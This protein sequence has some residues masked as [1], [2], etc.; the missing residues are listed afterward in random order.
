VTRYAWWL[1]ALLCISIAASA[2]EPAIEARLEPQ[3]IGIEDTARLTVTIW[4][5]GNAIPKLGE[6]S[7]L[8][9]VYGPV[10]ESQFRWV[11][12]VASSSVNFI[13]TLRPLQVGAAQVGSI[14]AQVGGVPLATEPLTAVVVQGRLAPTPGPQ[15]PIP[16]WEP[17]QGAAGRSRKI[18]LR[19]LTEKRELYLGE[20]VTVRLVLDTNVA[21]VESFELVSPPTFPGWWTQQVKL[22]QPIPPQ[23]VEVQ[24]ARFYRHHLISHVLIPLRSGD[25]T[26]PTVTARIGVR[27]RRLFTTGQAVERSTEEL[28]LTVKERPIPPD[29]FNGAVGSLQYRAELQP[30]EIEL[31]ESAVLTIELSGIGNLPLVEAPPLWPGC[32]DCDTYPPEEDSNVQIDDSGIHGTRTW[33]TTIVP[34]SPG[35]LRLDPVILAYFDPQAGSYRRQTI[36]AMQLKVSPPQV[37]ATPAVQATPVPEAATAEVRSRPLT[38]PSRSFSWISVAAALMVGLVTGGSLT[39]LLMRRRASAIPPRRKGQTPAQRARELQIALER[40]WIGIDAHQTAALQSQVE[41]L[42]K[43]LEAVRFAPGRADHTYTV[44][45]LEA[46]MKQLIG[47]P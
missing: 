43:E 8:E 45:D 14:T 19:H 5:A 29:G 36:G 11:N 25:L 23:L 31:G 37:T 4:E 18:V 47:R 44:S 6:M 42:R 26:L 2:G 30:E 35:Q 32:H 13:Y 7:N 33:R 12:G 38:D 28:T 1:A 17:P 22:S 40:W 9:V 3:R 20:P 21:G 16:S 41:E 10:T 46:K 27:G 24:G 15:R 34:R 39:W